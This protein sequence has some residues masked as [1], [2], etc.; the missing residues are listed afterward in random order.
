[1]ASEGAYDLWTVIYVGEPIPFLAWKI[2]TER[3]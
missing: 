1:M 2:K 3:Q